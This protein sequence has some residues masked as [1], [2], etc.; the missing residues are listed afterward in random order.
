MSSPN[1][2]L[3]RNRSVFA[4]SVSRRQK[5]VWSCESGYEHYNTS[6]QKTERRH[7]ELI[8]LPQ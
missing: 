2:Y 7:F 6:R 4:R 1:H 3:G 5:E 8:L